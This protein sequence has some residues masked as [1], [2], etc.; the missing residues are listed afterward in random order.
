MSNIL[1]AEEY[2]RA[3]PA[4]G[5]LQGPTARA[6]RQ[7]LVDAEQAATKRFTDA[8]LQEIENNRRAADLPSLTADEVK[9]ISGRINNILREAALRDFVHPEEA[10]NRL[11][12]N[13]DQ[14]RRDASVTKRKPKQKAEEYEGRLRRQ[15]NA[16][17][18]EG[19]MAERKEAL[20]GRIEKAQIG[21]A[22]V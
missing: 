16:P 2:R 1:K 7:T 21:R 13:I 22:H 15:F 18:P 17:A 5:T 20:V 4:T 19:T 10:I 9:T 6:E 3:N 8:V 14:I 12:E 11:R